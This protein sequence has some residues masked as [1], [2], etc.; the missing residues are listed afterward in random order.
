MKSFHEI[1]YFFLDDYSIEPQ[2][3]ALNEFLEQ[4]NIIQYLSTE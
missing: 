3:D 1:V 4:I 2:L